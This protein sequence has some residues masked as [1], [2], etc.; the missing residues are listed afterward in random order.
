M[1][2]SLESELQEPAGATSKRDQP[3]KKGDEVTKLHVSLSKTFQ[4]SLEFA[5]NH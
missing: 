5:K 1:A 2:A 3:E 4:A